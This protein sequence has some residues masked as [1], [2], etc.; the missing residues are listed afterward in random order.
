MTSALSQNSPRYLSKSRF[1]LGL[2]C[3]TKLYYTGKKKEY[4]D[5]SLSDPFLK[6]LAEGGFQVGE[7]AKYM[8]CEDP[9]ADKVTVETLDYT[10][11]LRI[12]A[13]M[14]SRPGK[15]I[16]A[17]GAFLYNNL[18]VRADI[19]VKQGNR[20]DLYE[21]KAKSFSADEITDDVFISYKGKAN[22]GISSKWKG[23]LYDLAFQKHVMIH[24]LPGFEINAHLL[25][26]NKDESVTIDGLN[27]KF[28]IHREGTRAKAEPELGLKRAA[29]GKIPMKAIKLDQIVDKIWHQ[30]PVP[31]SYK[32]GIHFGDFV[33]LCEDIYSKGERHFESIGTKCKSCQFYT[34]SNDTDV[35][36]SGLY[37]CWK[38]HTGYSDDLL[39][40]ALILELWGGGT[41]VFIKQGVY[42]LENLDESLIKEKKKKDEEK[43]GLDSASR[44][45]EQ[46]RRVKAGDATS[47][48]DAMGM[49]AEIEN[50]KWPLHMIDFETSTVA[51]P[52]HKNT[53]PYQGIAFQFSHHIMHE[54]GIVEHADQFLH[55][56]Q[57]VYPNIEFIRALKKSLSNDEGSVFRYHNHE[58][59]YLRMIYKQLGMGLGDVDKNERKELMDFIDS[60]TRW[61][62]D[63]DDKYIHGNRAMIDLYDLVLRFY[64]PPY[65]RGSNSLKQILP[66]IIHDSKY[67]RV[68]YGTAGKY[69]KE[70]QI[71]SLNFDDHIWIRE[72]KNKDP[73]KTLP[74]VFDGV[75][76]ETLDNLVKD[77]DDLAGGG[78][79]LT[80]YN[81]LQ[82]SEVPV[83][84]RK[85]I[86][87]ALLRY[88][89]LD[90]LA[91]V[92]IVEG[93]MN[94]E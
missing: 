3:I 12:T 74:T 19:V 27:Q 87:D 56:E 58:N 51:L 25:L 9:V 2:E 24:A 85:L 28:K 43:D 57:E 88:C 8:F 65:A 48:F 36:K 68:K 38:N 4:Q 80:A 30:Y 16:I 83:A 49:K 35:M 66:S 23:Y 44:K 53:K 13:E 90:T 18:F 84:E 73:Y 14:L 31:N 6:A 37:E 69:G 72:E 79:A 77:F 26:V 76:R 50:W 92:M 75:D 33:Q 11:S 41:D 64:Y 5:Q 94:W 32:L 82:F 29:L 62:I 60:I 46:I 1:K 81:Y 21:V 89:E 15:V 78:A 61:K 55:F 10:E 45:V 71:K 91:M 20:I 86:A 54:N 40:K 63:G 67:L 93:W 7:L 42:L 70:L 22:E 17:E 52:F 59:T 34:S 47:Y 39:K